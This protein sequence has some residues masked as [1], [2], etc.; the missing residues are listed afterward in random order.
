MATTLQS[1]KHFQPYMASCSLQTTSAP[2]RPPTMR[3]FR[4]PRQRRGRG[5]SVHLRLAARTRL[6]QTSACAA[7]AAVRSRLQWQAGSEVRLT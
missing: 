7:P 4:T 5:T 2:K 6:A 1:P 3:P